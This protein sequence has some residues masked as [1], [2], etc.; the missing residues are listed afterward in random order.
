MDTS[1]AIKTMIDSQNQAYKGSLEAFMKQVSDNVKGLETVIN[2]LKRSLEFTQKEVEDLKHEQK[3]HIQER[4]KDQERIYQLKE[5]LQT[6]DKVIKEL[7]GRANYQEDYS[8]RNNL[9]I[10]GIEER[11]QGET[12]EQ[13]ANIV[14]KLLQ[15]KLQMPNIELERAH[16][17]GR[18]DNNLTR[19]IIAR[20]TWYVDRE[21][22]L[23]NVTK[24][25]GTR[26][27]INE[28]L[29]PASNNIR[30]SQLPQL[31]QARSEGKV[32]F[33]RHTR[34]IIKEG[35]T[36]SHGDQQGGEAPTQGVDTH[37]GPSEPRNDVTGTGK[38][39][40]TDLSAGA[41]AVAGGEVGAVGSPRGDVM[42]VSAA[43]AWAGSGDASRQSKAS[44]GRGRGQAST[45]ASRVQK[46]SSETSY[47]YTRSGGLKK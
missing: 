17:V 34:L 19:P 27:F 9:Q 22:V 20:F 30:K 7:E 38:D 6:C 41:S 39:A 2:D 4:K 5:E 21:A 3:Q 32:A 40:G 10:I 16:R 13:T 24:L 29:C 45:P 23:R 14:G 43:G 12:W 46:G 28:D 47:R 37:A 33:F 42:D 8:R 25:R 11:P 35:T 18:R 15:D 44:G 1:T 26:I 31:K 36:S